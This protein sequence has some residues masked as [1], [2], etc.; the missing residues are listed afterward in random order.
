MA[1]GLLAGA[2]EL[3]RPLVRCLRDAGVAPPPPLPSRERAAQVFEQLFQAYE[4]K[5]PKKALRDFRRSQWVDAGKA[6]YD[7]PGERLLALEYKTSPQ[8]RSLWWVWDLGPT[9]AFLAF[10]FSF[11]IVTLGIGIFRRAPQNPLRLFRNSP[12]AA[13][14]QHVAVYG[15]VRTVADRTRGRRSCS[16]DA[17][18]SAGR[19]GARWTTACARMTG[20]AVPLCLRAADA[21]CVGR[22]QAAQ[23]DAQ[24]PHAGHR[25]CA[26]Q[27]PGA[28][29]R[30]DRR[31]VLGRGRLRR[32]AA[33]A[34]LRGRGARPPTGRARWFPTLNLTRACQCPPRLG[35]VVEARA[36]PAGS[37]RWFL[38]MQGVT[39]GPAPAATRRRASWAAWSGCGR[40]LLGGRALLVLV[41]RELALLVKA[42]VC[43]SRRMR[44]T[45][46]TGLGW[47]SAA[48]ARVH[49]QPGRG[50]AGTAFRHLLCRG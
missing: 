46:K 25:V 19:S 12:R 50:N 3:P 17:Q 30:Q 21:R 43:E 16:A 22:A 31:A 39:A 11:L 14:H 42:L 36:P 32:G 5:L 4:Q 37:A 23:A 28:Q 35:Y 45:S 1:G 20:R 7:C 40:A 24:R 18:G 33:Q 44:I 49:P 2:S 9:Y 29:G 6:E 41:D 10:S 34:G 47:Q 13:A 15:I 27:G 8:E 38:G 48:A 26:E